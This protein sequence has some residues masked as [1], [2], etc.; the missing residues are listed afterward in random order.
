MIIATIGIILLLFST[1]VQACGSKAIRPISDFTDTNTDIAGWGDPA[2]D[3]MLIA[4]PHGCDYGYPMEYIVNCRH[5]GFVLEEDLGDGRI[6]YKI[7]L[8][9]KGAILQIFYDVGMWWLPDENGVY[10]QLMFT[11]EMNYFFTT[12]IIVYGEFG[13]PVPWLWYV[14]FF[15]GG[16]TLFQTLIAMGT[17]T[18]MES[19]ETA[20]V[21]IEMVGILVDGEYEW[22]IET[23]EFY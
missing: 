14:W 9:V 17:G 19:G 1:S 23:I 21:K 7:Y 3:P 22:P 6:K 15:G 12:T 10:Q 11:G 13:G 18:L 2:W 16:E 8:Y 5:Y 4:V 20:N